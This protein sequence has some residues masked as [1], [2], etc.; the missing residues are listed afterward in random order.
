D[1]LDTMSCLG[2]EVAPELLAVA[3]ELGAEAVEERLEPALAAGLLV[4]DRA[5]G[6]VLFRHDRVQE[7][8]VA[9]LEPAERARLQLRVAR[10]LAADARFEH[11]AAEPYLHV[12]AE[13]QD[14][15]ERRRVVTLLRAAAA[16]TRQV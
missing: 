3:C 8:A 14:P 2:V 15:A 7:A 16:R 5:A 12:L 10:R 4:E 1:V 13:L 6:A 9:R 11:L